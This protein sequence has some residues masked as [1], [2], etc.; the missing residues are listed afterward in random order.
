MHPKTKS[1]KQE[2]EGKELAESSSSGVSSEKPSSNSGVGS[3]KGS[4]IMRELVA[5][6]LEESSSSG[7]SSD[8]T[9]VSLL[10]SMH[11]WI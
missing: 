4:I 2:I 9:K 10:P 11:Y 5:K 7:V 8:K 6:D 3:K 1:M